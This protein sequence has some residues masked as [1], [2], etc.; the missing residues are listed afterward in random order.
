VVLIGSLIGWTIRAVAERPLSS[1]ERALTA[2]LS[3]V[4]ALP[5]A[6][7]EVQRLR[8]GA[9]RNTA[10]MLARADTLARATLPSLAAY[11]LVAAPGRLWALLHRA[12]S[13]PPIVEVAALVAAVGVAAGVLWRGRT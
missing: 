8:R 9:W 3:V 6:G 11:A 4:L 2:A 13:A 1:V 12:P 7:V 5:L 10:T